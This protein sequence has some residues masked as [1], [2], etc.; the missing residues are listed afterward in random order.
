MPSSAS[1]MRRKKVFVVCGC[2]HIHTCIHVCFY[3]C[4]YVC[5]YVCM[6]D[7]VWVCVFMYVCLDVYV[8]CVY[9]IYVD[10]LCVFTSW[11]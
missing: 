2:N 4:V 1:S 6:G 5:M 9:I 3:L 7:P 8:L 10:V 11:I